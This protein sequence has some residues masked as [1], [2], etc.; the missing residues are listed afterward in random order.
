MRLATFGTLSNTALSVGAGALTQSPDY[1]YLA[2]P[3]AEASGVFWLA[4]LAVFTFHHRREIRVFMHS[5]LFIVGCFVVALLAVGG[6]SYALGTRSLADIS[7][8]KKTA[9]PFPSVRAQEQFLKDP[10]LG[11]WLD[12]KTPLVFL[13]TPTQTT[14]RLRLLVEYSLY[15]NGWMSPVR[16]EIYPIKEPVK[17]QRVKVT[18]ARI[19]T[20]QNGGMEDLWWGTDPSSDNLVANNP[21]YAGGAATLTRGR[22]VVIGADNK[23]QNALYFQIVR[24]TN[25][26][27][28][29]PRFTILQGRDVTDWI[30]DWEK[31]N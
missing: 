20:K 24:A 15:R 27:K 12:P 19:G 26:E 18:V 5:W 30:S 10:V 23:E 28:G 16:F 7:A 14:D 25:D 3:L 21:V 8:E 31:N 13:G 6:G 9:A 2:L 22:I 1:S 17:G 11:I 4:L 29:N